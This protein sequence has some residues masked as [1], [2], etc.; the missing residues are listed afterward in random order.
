VFKRFS[1]LI[2]FVILLAACTNS[3]SANVSFLVFGDAAE[4][5]AYQSLVDAFSEKYPDIAVEMAHIPSQGDYRTRL[6]TDYAAGTPPDV[7]FMNYRHY[8]AFAAKGLL[9]PLAP[10]LAESDLIQPD[11]FYPIA[12][13]AFTWQGEL[14][15]MP[16][17]ISSLVVYYNQDLF[18]AAGLPYPADDWTWE[19]FLNT[20]VTLT[21]DTDGDGQIDQYGL[22]IE[23]SI[24]RL[25]PFVWQNGGQVVDDDAHPTRLF[26]DVFPA[27]EALEWFTA[28]QT[29]HHVVPDRIAETAQ[30]SESRFVAGTTAM[31]LNSRRSTP[32]FREIEKFTWDVAPLPRGQQAAGVLHSDAYCLSA[33]AQDKE[34]AWK[35]IEFA[36]SPEGQTIVAQAGR[37]V[38]SL[39]AVAESPAFLDP[40]QPPSRS[41]VWLDTADTLR[42]V[43]IV[44]TWE[45]I[46][47]VADE[48]LERAFYGDISPLDA[49]KNA[50]IRTA[51]Y[52][53]LGE[54]PGQ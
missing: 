4:R 43:P 5:Q 51:E 12:L 8:G 37:T 48:E 7:S 28:L 30:D 13:D 15:C 27:L 35:F 31:Y 25:A 46:E 10:Y 16:Q 38:P 21:Q 39:T 22:G 54:K 14:V 11:D 26:L 44:S 50:R 42:L 2:L 45:E 47:S 53:L 32:T 52:F 33:T 29:E 34:A 19:T 3:E 40:A 18:D 9:E 24:Q 23:P 41:R 17:N 49:A 1:F 36:N 6:A 20:A